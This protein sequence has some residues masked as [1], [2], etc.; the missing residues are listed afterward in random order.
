[1]S[2]LFANLGIRIEFVGAAYA[3]IARRSQCYD[4]TKGNSSQQRAIRKDI[5]HL[6]EK[7]CDKIKEVF[8]RYAFKMQIYNQTL[9]FSFY[10]IKLLR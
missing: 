2:N 9:N 10:F 7:F 6:S 4:G 8:D 1:M 3:T 5:F